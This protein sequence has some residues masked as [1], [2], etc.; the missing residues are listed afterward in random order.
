MRLKRIKLSG[1][2]SFVDP[3]VIPF[4]SNLTAIVGPNGCGKSNV[5]DAV[6]WVLGEIS[7]KELRGEAMSDVIFNGSGNR[8]PLGQASIEI[9]FDNSAGKCGGEYAKYNEIAIRREVTRDGGSNYYLN[10]TRCRRKDILDIFLGTGLGLN[11][12][13]I[14]G[15]GTIAQMVEAKPE[16]LRLHLEEAAGVSKYKERRRETES[17][18]E[19]TKENLARLNDIR[20]EIESQLKTLKRQAN[21]ASFYRKLREEERLCKARI[22]ACH[23]DELGREKQELGSNILT[24]E[25]ALEAKISEQTKVESAM[26]VLHQEQ[27]MRNDTF[28]AVQQK[29]YDFG[30]EISTLEQRIHYDQKRKEE[31]LQNIEHLQKDLAGA[32]EHKD[33]D[34]QQLAMLEAELA[35]EIELE[36]TLI[37]DQESSWQSFLNTEE[38]NRIAQKHWDDFNAQS[39]ELKAGI[40]R[41]QANLENWQNTVQREM[42][43]IEKLRR[44]AEGL[45]YSALLQEITLLQGSSSELLPKEKELQDRLQIFQSSIVELR[46][47]IQSESRELDNARRALQELTGKKSALEALQKESLAGKDEK[48]KKWLEDGNVVVK[49]RLAKELDVVSGWEK[50]VETVLADYLDAICVPDWQKLET[51]LPTLEKR[52]SEDLTFLT[53][54]E[55]TESITKKSLPLLASKVKSLYVLDILKNVYAAEDL[56]KALDLRPNLELHESI[57]TQDGIWIGSN[58]L[59]IA[60]EGGTRNSVLERE[61]ELRTLADKIQETENAVSKLEVTVETATNK[62]HEIEGEQEKVRQVWHGLNEEKTQLLSAISAKEARFEHLKERSVVI[63]EEIAKHNLSLIEAKQS[64]QSLENSW[65]TILSSEEGHE[66]KRKE[67]LEERDTKLL[68]VTTA[69]QMAQNSKDKL[70]NWYR[71]KEVFENQISNLKQ[72][73]DRFTKQFEAFNQRQND[74]QEKI[75]EIA[76]AETLLQSDLEEKLEKRIGVEN[77]LLVAKEAVSVVENSLR[78]YEKERALLQESLENMRSGL[79]KLRL[80]KQSI[81]LTIANHVNNITE[82]GFVLEEFLPQVI[83]EREQ[84]NVV[85]E[86]LH[87]QLERIAKRLE[88]LGPINLAA[89]DEYNKQK[90]RKDYLDRQNDDLLAALTTLQDAIHKIDAESKQKFKNTFDIINENLQKLFPKIF[91]GGKATLEMIGDDVLNS[92]VAIYAQP[93]GKRNS[94]IHLLSGGEKALTAIAF[95]FSIFQ[96][97][98]APFCLLDEVDAPFDDENVGRFCRLVKEMAESIQ[99][100]YIT[101]NKVSMEIS[102]QLLGVT[103]QE[104][105]VSRIVSVDVAE[106]LKMV[107]V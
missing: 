8:K 33:N 18:I 53:K 19:Q 86:T 94:S 10:G 14:I 85:I 43:L 84:G 12:Y 25:V 9:V 32:S 76:A 50:A 40:V 69:R 11:T 30:S 88:R 96:V 34:A 90:E 17:R 13:A 101:H 28:Q 62:L 63:E 37:I 82:L 51:L 73:L 103:M 60:A 6:R 87:A 56:K 98:P 97:N 81:D 83:L 48:A 59:R 20:T 5:I 61:K 22:E 67:L 102:D 74:I 44:E 100:I 31:F 23:L 58:W 27:V 64:L 89:I 79:E 35:K 41:E 65:Q 78:S 66:V 106:A 95:I 77:E 70:D 92:G 29:Y 57:V 16:D 72:N 1:F 45:E 24:S 75:S 39:S 54:T 36:P 107:E 49:S 55:A 80:S 21:I 105:G 38:E 2:K 91:N 99:F 26:E 3:T 104:A 93:P 52:F 42:E 71:R 7:A 4:S 47:S 15:Q 68:A 46:T